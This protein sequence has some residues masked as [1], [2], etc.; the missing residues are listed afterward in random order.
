MNY[1]STE[2]EKTCIGQFVSLIR[3]ANIETHG[4]QVSIGAANV[5]K[6]P[7]HGGVRQLQMLC[8]GQVFLMNLNFIFEA[9]A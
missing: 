2:K 7:E 8:H 4:M 9:G 5:T 3:K 6:K 1:I